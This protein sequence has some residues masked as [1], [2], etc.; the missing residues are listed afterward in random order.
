MMRGP[1]RRLGVRGGGTKLA[2]LR[3]GSALDLEL[4]TTGLARV[5][6]HAHGDLTATVQAGLRLADLQA[7]LANKGQRLAID[8]PLGPGDAASLGGIFATDDAGP[9][10]L[11][12][13]TLRALTVGATVVLA[14]GTV[15]RS[16]GKVIKNVAG[17]DLCKL[18]CGARGTLGVVAELTVRLHPIPPAERTLS[19]RVPAV[20]A[21]KRA[22]GLRSGRL[23]P[24]AVTHFDGA[25][26]ARF[27]GSEAF[28]EGQVDAASAHLGGELEC[29][30]DADSRAAWAAHT[31][32]RRAGPGEAWLVCRTLPGAVAAVAQAAEAEDAVAE[33]VL[34]PLLGACA[35][36]LAG[37]VE[38]MA[39]A[40][41]RLRARARAEG[42]SARLQGRPP[43]LD[44]IVDPFGPWPSGLPVMRAV[45]RAL[46][47][48]DRMLSGRFLPEE[49]DPR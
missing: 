31:A 11:A 27:E 3:S 8:P 2:W 16:G 22:L 12:F 25:L 30:E 49:G 21:A 39:V 13:G 32:T 6:E 28:V 18:F 34:D 9:G 33:V 47:P 46:D 45:K 38:A 24:T 5:V 44:A 20:E 35:A 17:Y 14:D 48:E 29:L 43:E 10:A 41:R 19:A 1:A 37:S 40:V 15:A 36:R 26:W 7:Q 23:Q 42:G 4:D